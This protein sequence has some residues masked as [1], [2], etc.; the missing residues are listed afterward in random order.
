MRSIVELLR[1][2]PRESDYKLPE[3]PPLP[4]REL[5]LLYLLAAKGNLTRD[6]VIMLAKK[7]SEKG[8]PT[9][10]LQVASEAGILPGKAQKDGK[11]IPERKYRNDPFL[12]YVAIKYEKSEEQAP[13][14][15][16]TYRYRT[17]D[18]SFTDSGV[19]RPL[20]MELYGLFT[21]GEVSVE[22]MDTEQEAFCPTDMGK[23]LAKAMC[24]NFDYA[25]NWRRAISESQIVKAGPYVTELVSRAA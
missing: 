9:P 4:P 17:V 10:L 22:N 18:D 24:F 15:D 2:K 8:N 13:D 23:S 25:I 16:Y 7:L 5:A 6:D 19:A 21:T 20:F 1:P 3:K 14:L 11:L 12:N